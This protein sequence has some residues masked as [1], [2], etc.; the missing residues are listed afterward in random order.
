ME[1]YLHLLSRG[2]KIGLTLIR[3]SI[4]IVF[5]WIGLL[6]FVPYEADS[7]TPFVAN[8]PLMSFF[9]E[10]SEDYKQY[11][12][13]EGEYKPEARAWQTANNTYGFSNGLGVVEVIIALLVLANPVNR[14]LGLL[15]GLMAF[16][17]PLVTLSFLIT[18]PEAWV[19]ALGDAHH[20]FPYLSGAGRL[21]LKD[22]L[23]LAGAVMI[24]ADS[25]REILKQR[26]NESSSTLKTEY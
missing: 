3:L 23:M 16:T 26:S 18:T 15:G 24:M 7:I 13:H 8:S 9:Y 12:T 6:K 14:W 17:T 10:H 11:P 22:T 2:D 4:A 20:G 25:A 19:P 1:K 5:M 21:V